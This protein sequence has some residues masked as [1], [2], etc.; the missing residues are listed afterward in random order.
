[1][2][3]ARRIIFTAGIA[4][5]S[6]CASYRAGAPAG[7]IDVI[8]HRGASA[9]APENTL[10]AFALAEEMGA[11]WFELDCTLSKDGQVVVIHDDDL[12]RTTGRDAQVRD[13]TLAELRR[14][15]A[16]SWFDPRFREQYVPS[17]EEALDLA[18]GRI[19]VYIEIKDSD[20]DRELTRQ[21]LALASGHERLL[22]RFH[23]EMMELIADSGTR[24]LELT[25]RVI[26]AVDERNM[27]EQ[28]V[29]QSFSPIACAVAL[30]EEPHL[31]TELLA[32][33]DEDDPEQWPL[34]LRWAALLDPAGFNVNRR[35]VTPELVRDFHARGKTVAVWTVNDSEEM[36]RLASLGVDAIITDKPDVALEVLGPAGN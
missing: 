4:A 3:Y 29:I 30:A 32:S 1:M 26:H 33:S 13:L 28:I 12:L 19:G 36:R 11:H 10:A 35:D 15:D 21:L 22:P 20:D 18:K 31:R 2:R 17:L 9:Y 8:A 16:G 25:L 5:L 7:R 27:D 6:G 14:A 34:Y 24:N 23:Q